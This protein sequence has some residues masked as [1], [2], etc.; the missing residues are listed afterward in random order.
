MNS[1]ER[2]SLE[3]VDPQIKRF[4]SA[5]EEYERCKQALDVALKGD[6]ETQKKY[7]LKRFRESEEELAK[8]C[9]FNFDDHRLL[10]YDYGAITALAVELGVSLNKLSEILDL[11]VFDGRIT[12]FFLRVHLFLKDIHF[13]FSR[14]RHVR[15]I[16][17]NLSFKQ[18]E[19]TL[20]PPAS[21]ETVQ[22]HG[23]SYQNHNFKCI[24]ARRCDKLESLICSNIALNQVYLSG[25][26]IRRIFLS[27]VG[28]PERFILNAVKD[29]ESL[30]I[31][32]IYTTSTRAEIILQNLQSLGHVEV[33]VYGSPRTN[34]VL[35]GCPKLARMKLG[36]VLSISGLDKTAEA[37]EELEITSSSFSSLRLGRKP[38]L[39]K[40]SIRSH[41]STTLSLDVSGCQNLK[42]LDL[43]YGYF[44]QDGIEIKGL[45]SAHRGMTLK[46]LGVD[47]PGSFINRVESLGIKIITSSGMQSGIPRVLGSSFLPPP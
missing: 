32:Q 27:Y 24:D 10:A 34:M 28:L 9:V 23:T 3:T 12:E 19:V 20:V 16:G 2:V 33:N 35:Y 42:E 25:S 40:L 47:L 7:W 5:Y 21:A 26:S 18:D 36:R 17:L 37:L 41:E 45:S 4:I 22:I 39:S 8:A 30:R 14:L 38:N 31:D 43:S 13:D 29:L 11:E 6:D 46:A 1:L 44:R 15:K